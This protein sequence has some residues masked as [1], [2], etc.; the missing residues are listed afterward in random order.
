MKKCIKCG[1]EKKINK[2]NFYFRKSKN[3]TYICNSKCIVCI[4]LDRKIYRENNKEK[5]KATK[6]IYRENNKEKVLA[7]SKKWIDENKKSYEEYQ[8][9]YR[10]LNREKSKERHKNNKEKEQKQ[11]KEWESKNKEK[12]NKYRSER[13]KNNCIISIREGF[14]RAI[15]KALKKNCSSKKGNSCL[16]YL[17]YTIDELKKHLQ[18]LWKPWMNWDNYGKYKT[19]GPRKWHIDHVI[20]QSLLPYH[21]MDHINFQ[22]CWALS[23]LRPLDAV[24]NMS[25]GKNVI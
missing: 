14:G 19:G 10:E 12:R 17:P 7:A 16:L 24:Q 25:K 20:P 13:R 1:E 22:K 2:D 21:S 3:N 18:S 11:N 6:K 5:I 9:K 23:N 4:K 15:N 8:N